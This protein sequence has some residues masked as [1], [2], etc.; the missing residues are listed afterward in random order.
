MQPSQKGSSI[1]LRSYL[2]WLGLSCIVSV[3]SYGA[4]AWVFG[5]PGFARLT[6]VVAC[7]F[8]TSTLIPGALLRRGKTEAA[9]LWTA[10][11]FAALVP[12]AT[13]ALPRF[14]VALLSVPFM[15]A[16]LG[17]HYLRGRVL[18]LVLWAG[19]AGGAA[20]AMI[21]LFADPAPELPSVLLKVVNIVFFAVGSAN[22]T[23]MLRQFQRRLVEDVAR[24][25]R[26]AADLH[27]ARDALEVRAREVDSLNVE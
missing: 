1:R 18:T 10:L 20:A 12:A 15:T 24:L 19:V 21:G 22:V 6:A 3:A 13:L 25:E 27:A 16:L 8:V 7:F 2:R 4:L 11:S 23:V 9:A 26:A 14:F 5:S 17:F